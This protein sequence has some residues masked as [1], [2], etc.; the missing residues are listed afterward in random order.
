M[1][2]EVPYHAMC[3]QKRLNV[4]GGEIGLPEDPSW[5]KIPQQ[6]LNGGL[7]QKSNVE[8]NNTL[9]FKANVA[10]DYNTINLTNINNANIID[11]VD[12]RENIDPSSEN[13]INI[14]NKEIA[15]G[16]QISTSICNEKQNIRN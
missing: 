1:H 3:M 9:E 10:K 16:E 15:M 14:I 8:D 12:I 13:N 5:P 11:S 7:L 2:A 4:R 6:L